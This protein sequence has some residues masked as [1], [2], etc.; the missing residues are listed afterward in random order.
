MVRR[1]FNEQYGAKSE[2][3]EMPI[4]RYVSE[5]KMIFHVLDIDIHVVLHV[6]FRL[7]KRIEETYSL[8]YIRIQNA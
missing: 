1:K 5:M 8:Q 7:M 6:F 2:A 3:L 4:K